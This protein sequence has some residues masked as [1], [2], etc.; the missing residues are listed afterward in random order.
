MINGH[1]V[2]QKQMSDVSVFVQ[3]QDIFVG[4]LTVKEHLMFHARLR[5]V[6]STKAEIRQR[7]EDVMEQ[8]LLKKCE[9]VLIGVP[10]KIK[11]VSGGEAKRLAFAAEVL[12]LILF[13]GSWMSE[14]E[15]NQVVIGSLWATGFKENRNA[16]V[17]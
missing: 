6:H 3:Q 13:S 12:R 17:S 8:M 7:V 1:V 4:T 2:D 16:V 11:G 9:N 14:N 5:M 10:E 15:E